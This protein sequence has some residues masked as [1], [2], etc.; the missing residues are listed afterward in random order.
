MSPRDHHAPLQG[1][2]LALG[3]SGSALRH[4]LFTEERREAKN[5][6]GQEKMLAAKAQIAHANTALQHKLTTTEENTPWKKQDFGLTPHADSVLRHDLFA[7]EVSEQARKDASSLATRP[8]LGNPMKSRGRHSQLAQA[9]SKNELDNAFLERAIAKENAKKQKENDKLLHRMQRVVPS[10]AHKDSDL[11]NA[12]GIK[13]E[14]E[15]AKESAPV[16]PLKPDE[17][18]RKG[19]SKSKKE[20]SSS[21]GAGK[22]LSKEEK[23]FLKKVAKANKKDRKRVDEEVNMLNK[24]L[25]GDKKEKKEK[26]KEKE[27][28]AQTEK[29]ERKELDD[30]VKAAS[31]SSNVDK[32][33]AFAAAKRRADELRGVHPPCCRSPAP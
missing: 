2:C 24:A 30:R 10:F 6:D 17:V 32:A 22:P 27:R 11:G 4:E 33:D 25:H 12:L 18:E 31:S 16:N 13:K 19:K 20:A 9:K 3:V 7:A 8:Q 1:A 15:T 23:A 21:S 29:E 26:E 28:E 5:D 14:K